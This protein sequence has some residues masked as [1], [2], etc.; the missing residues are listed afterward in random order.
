M[1]SAEELIAKYPKL[2]GESFYIECHS[3]WYN[4]IDSLAQSIESYTKYSLTYEKP[5]DELQFSQIKEKFGILRI[6]MNNADETITNMIDL[7]ESFSATVCECCGCPGQR[8]GGSWIRT[9]C[10][11][12]FGISH[13]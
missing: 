5:E 4:I 10:D 6:Y 9:Q 13:Q 2:F 3:G 12:C 11:T 1:L 7:S 8:R